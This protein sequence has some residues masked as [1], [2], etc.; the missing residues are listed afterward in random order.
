MTFGEHGEPLAQ[1]ME[2]ASYGGSDDLD[3]DED[4]A[5]GDS[6]MSAFAEGRSLDN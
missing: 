4:D 1:P 2:H 5:A 6:S 3:D